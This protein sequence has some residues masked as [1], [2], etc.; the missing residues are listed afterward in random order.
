M[1][2][3]KYTPIPETKYYKFNFMVLGIVGINLFMFLI[4]TLTAAKIET[5]V[6]FSTSLVM[7]LFFGVL[8]LYYYLRYR[9]YLNLDVKYIQIVKLEKVVSSYTGLVA[10]EVEM[11]IDSEMQK[12]ETLAVFNSGLIKINSIENYSNKTV[13]VGYDKRF[14]SCVVLEVIE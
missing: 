4:I 14:K 3:V 13:R 1:E 7:F 6:I 8:T 10:F 9:Y 12:V 2:E 5:S 11:E